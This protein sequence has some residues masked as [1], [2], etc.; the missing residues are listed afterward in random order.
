MVDLSDTPAG[1]ISRLDAAIARR[2]STLV[3]K[4]GDISAPSATVTVKGYETDIDP[5]KF[6]GNSKQ[7]D[8]LIILS[9]T[10]LGAFGEPLEDDWTELGGR[11]RSVYFV[12]RKMLANVLVRLELM[13]RGAP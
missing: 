9:P 2:G 1:A 5:T 6:V 8:S 13:V 11:T 10:G 4:R 3:L 7:G 12:R